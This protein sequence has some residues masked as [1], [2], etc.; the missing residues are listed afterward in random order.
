MK[1]LSTRLEHEIS[2]RNSSKSLTGESSDPS[3][4][5]LSQTNT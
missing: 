2:G 3:T 5:R 4:P 1:K